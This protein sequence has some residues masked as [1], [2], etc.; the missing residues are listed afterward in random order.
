MSQEVILDMFFD[1]L[2]IEVPDW[3]QAFMDGRRLT[4]QCRYNLPR[5]KLIRGL[6]FGPPKAAKQQQPIYE[7]LAPRSEKLNL[8]HQFISLLLVV[9]VESGLIEVSPFIYYRYRF[10]TLFPRLW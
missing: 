4:S 6:V 8:T 5:L 7:Q 1:I 3:G 10:T 2:N 9:F